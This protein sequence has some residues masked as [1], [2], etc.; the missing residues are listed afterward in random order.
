MRD[1][2]SIVKY[3]KP[4]EKAVRLMESENKL[5]FTVAKDATKKEIKD[6]IEKIFKVKVE[7]VNTTIM[8]TGKKKAY[9]KLSLDTP[10][11]D[12]ATEMG[13]L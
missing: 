7:A 6:S 9:V 13:M 12:V 11:I 4:T 8:P 5:V 2:Y 10:A 1:P 3:P